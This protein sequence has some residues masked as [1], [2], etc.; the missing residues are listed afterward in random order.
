MGLPL[1]IH[2]AIRLGFSVHQP[3]IKGITH[4]GNPYLNIYPLVIEHRHGI[5]GP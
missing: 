3:A 5:D 4:F 2:P 1:A